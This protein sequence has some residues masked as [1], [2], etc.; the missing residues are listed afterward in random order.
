MGSQL[1]IGG[2]NQKDGKHTSVA[3]ESELKSLQD[4]I[5]NLESKLSFTYEESRQDLI[6]TGLNSNTD[7]FS[8][9]PDD[10]LP[11]SVGQEIKKKAFGQKRG[12][13]ASESSLPNYMRKQQVGRVSQEHIKT[14]SFSK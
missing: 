4:K 14:N 2:N 13:E 12:S 11:K 1:G 10:K 9:L 7:A 5:M 3:M 6:Q 8:S